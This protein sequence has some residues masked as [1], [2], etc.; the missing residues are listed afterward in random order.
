M[1]PQCQPSARCSAVAL[2]QCEQGSAGV[3]CR[4]S[5]QPVP[6]FARAIGGAAPLQPFAIDQGVDQ[7]VGF[8][9]LGRFCGR[10]V[11]TGH[12]ARPRMGQRA[13]RRCSVARLC[14]SAT[15]RSNGRMRSSARR[16]IAAVSPPGSD[17]TVDLHPSAA[18]AWHHMQ[19]HPW[20]QCA[21]DRRVRARASAQKDRLDRCRRPWQGFRTAG[22]DG[23]SMDGI[24]GARDGSRRG[25]TRGALIRK[26]ARIIGVEGLSLDTA[27]GERTA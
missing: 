18:G 24:V 10:T 8:S 26:G 4:V 5:N 22:Y 15:C 12:R 3:P 6:V 7:S 27:C 17:G 14:A 16:E 2:D 19:C 20:L 21:Y 23:R 13:C 11:S 9:R 1:S 25:G